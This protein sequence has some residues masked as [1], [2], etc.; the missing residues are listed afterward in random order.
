VVDPEALAALDLQLW[1]RTGL[2]AARRLNCNQST[3][4]R[5]AQHTLR[6]FGLK[7]LRDG[8]DWVLRGNQELLAME[9]AV[10]QLYRLLRR[11][12]LRLEADNWIGNLLAA[13]PP[14]GW[15]GG[16]YDNLLPRR[17]LQLLRERIID[18]WLTSLK[19]EFPDPD[20]PEWLLLDI[21]RLP[22]QL[23]SDRAHP[24]AREQGLELHDLQRFPKLTLPEGLLPM[25][26]RALRQK[27]LWDD[28]IQ[29][30]R[31][32]QDDWDGRT[33][34]GASL[35][36]GYSF[37]QVLRPELVALDYPLELPAGIVLVIRRDL[38][39]HDALHDCAM[40]LRRRAAALQPAHQALEVMAG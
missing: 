27:G 31:Y 4:S 37:T 28:P 16:T 35:C 29:V 20:D 15:L 21:G 24:L 8:G 30:L 32:S 19:N 25:T 11:Q 17:P 22:W 40:E 26:E 6:M 39:G 33:A 1:C 3:V 9:R 5:R 18:G 14:E 36:Y 34:D 23:M 10:H 38:A 13:P 2:E 7:P 12:D